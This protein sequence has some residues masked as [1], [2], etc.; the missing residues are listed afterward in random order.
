[1]SEHAP[2]SLVPNEGEGRMEVDKG[3]PQIVKNPL[4]RPLEL[5]GNNGPIVCGTDKGFSYK[6][7]NE[8]ALVIAPR[9]NAFA[10]I[11]GI[12]GG[13][14]G[15][16]NALLLARVFQANFLARRDDFESIQQHAHKLMKRHGLAG[17]NEGACYI[18]AVI[19]DNDEITIAQAGDVR[20]VVID[21][22]NNRVRFESADENMSSYR[23]IVLNSVSGND[24]GTTTLSHGNLI[25]RDRIIAATDGLWSNVSTE[26]VVELVHGKTAQDALK[27]LEEETRKRMK[28]EEGK[29]DNR[30][31]LI[32]DYTKRSSRSR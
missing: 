7:R 31:I 3:L 4:D 28:D 9:F 15:D 18:A 10:V 2:D 1:M 6:N 12:G 11:D 27:I 30:T 21:T 17:P 22:L 29:P 24:S 23:N 13:E 26:E 25:D 19:N 14:R 20:L 16:A 32:Y 5:E 8:D